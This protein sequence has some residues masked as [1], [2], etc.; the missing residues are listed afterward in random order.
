MKIAK[1]SDFT[2]LLLEKLFL[3]K[4]GHIFELEYLTVD[5]GENIKVDIT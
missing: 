2:L 4:F 1:N 3:I 5:P